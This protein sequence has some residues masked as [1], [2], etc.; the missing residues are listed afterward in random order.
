MREWTTNLSGLLRSFGS[1]SE[2][3]AEHVERL[4]QAGADV[5]ANCRRGGCHPCGYPSPPG[6][7]VDDEAQR[8]AQDAYASEVSRAAAEN[9]ASLRPVLRAMRWLTDAGVD[10]GVAELREH[11]YRHW[12]VSLPRVPALADVDIAA[13]WIL[14]RSPIRRGAERRAA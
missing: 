6:H 12:H 2:G 7:H 11:V 9:L 10:A 4:A 14:E 3:G 8:R 1:P 5:V 13:R